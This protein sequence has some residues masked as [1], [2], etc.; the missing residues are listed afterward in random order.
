MELYYRDAM[1]EIWNGDSRQLSNVEDE[2]V[3]LILTSPPY[4]NG[5]DFGHPD[6]IGFGQS[7]EEFIADLKRILG[8]CFRCLRP[9]RRIV[10]WVADLSHDNGLLRIPLT[11]DVHGEL[12]RVGFEFE[13]TIIWHS[14]GL[15]SAGEEAASLP[16]FER[17]PGGGPQYLIVYQKPGNPPRPSAEVVAAS[18]IPAPFRSRLEDSVWLVPERGKSSD[19]DEEWFSPEWAVIRFWSFVGDV[20]LDPFAGTGTF[21]AVAKRLGRRAIGIEV[22]ETTCE[23]AAEQC[24]NATQP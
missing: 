23:A 12:R 6:Q 15:A 18:R 24:R 3:D 14:P 8:E 10:T 2:C 21:C 7:Y 16:P 19:L 17:F 22:N 4:W 1:V 11:A 5:G 13:T 9:G 20:V